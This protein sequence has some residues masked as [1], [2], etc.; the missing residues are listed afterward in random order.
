MLVSESGLVR[1]PRYKSSSYHGPLQELPLEPFLS[2]RTGSI[3]PR[4]R[5]RSPGGSVTCSPPKRRILCAENEN[6]HEIAQRSMLATAS[7]NFASSSFNILPHGLTDLTLKPQFSLADRTLPKLVQ[8]GATLEADVLTEATISI[9]TPGP[10]MSHGDAQADAFLTRPPGLLLSA[11]ATQLMPPPSTIPPD[12]QS[13][14]YPGFDVYF[15][16]YDAYPDEKERE[17]KPDTQSKVGYYGNLF[18]VEPSRQDKE[19]EK[20]NVASIDVKDSPDGYPLVIGRSRRDRE[21]EKENV[22][23]RIPRHRGA[24]DGVPNHVAWVKANLFSPSLKRKEIGSAREAS[25]S[26]SPRTKRAREEFA[27][28]HRSDDILR[29]WEGNGSRLIN[30]SSVRMENERADAPL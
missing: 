15:D 17:P 18:V 22:P 30:T 4:K 7:G 12:R 16:P 13:F 27:I 21:Y 26:A 29:F 24:A 8:V 20:E 10:S 6:S 5:P 14:H 9:S 1:H 28:M 2:G 19:C 11:E 25:M 3:R 23:P